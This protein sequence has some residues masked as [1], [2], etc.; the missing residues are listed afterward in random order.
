MIELNIYNGVEVLRFIQTYTNILKLKSSGLFLNLE[1]VE[2]NFI[3]SNFLQE[4]EG[5]IK[6]WD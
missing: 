6:I 1:R 3:L 4:L 2:S 5:G